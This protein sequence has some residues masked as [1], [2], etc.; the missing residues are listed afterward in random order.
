[1]DIVLCS[2]SYLID[3]NESIYQYTLYERTYMCITNKASEIEKFFHSMQSSD[4]AIYEIFVIYANI[5]EYDKDLISHKCR[6]GYPGNYFSS[7][8]IIGYMADDKKLVIHDSYDIILGYNTEF[9]H[10]DNFTG[11]DVIT[12]NFVS[13]GG[14]LIKQCYPYKNTIVK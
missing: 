6:F 12:Y 3:D 4:N 8:Q 11:N 10:L 2:N 1:M 9:I 5:N 7:K 14:G 13:K